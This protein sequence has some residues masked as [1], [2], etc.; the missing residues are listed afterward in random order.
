MKKQKRYEVDDQSEISPK[1]EVFDN[2]IFK[3]DCE[4]L[5][6]SLKNSILTTDEH[7]QFSKELDSYIA[8]HER[9]LYSV[10]SNIV[11]K[12][13]EKELESLRINS[14]NLVQHATSS[15]SSNVKILMKLYD[16]IQLALNQFVVSTEIRAELQEEV[17]RLN[18]ETKN[19]K[20]NV[21]IAEN[22]LNDIKKDIKD[23]QKDYITILGIFAA[24]M[25]T[26]IS[27]LVFNSSVLENMHKSGIYKITYVAIMIIQG[28]IHLVYLLIDF[29]Y[30]LY[31]EEKYPYPQWLETFNFCALI[32]FVLSLVATL[33]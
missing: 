15:K 5:I 8:K 31:K 3:D 13:T 23:T 32:A 25:L 29:I 6:T 22:Q 18:A 2:E 7:E 27:A 4:R 10:V 33:S 12:A 30:R 14:I 17:N 1:I 16:H 21:T 28:T 26:F 11:S 20:N 9:L 24:I 19:I